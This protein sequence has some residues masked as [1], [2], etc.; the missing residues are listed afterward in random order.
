ME[1]L[2]LHR[3]LEAVMGMVNAAN[4]YFADSAPWALKNDPERR[5]AVLAAALDA[6]RRLALLVQPF[7]PESA[8]KLLD[9][10]GVAAKAR[11]FNGL[12]TPVATGTPLPA[13]QGVFPRWTETPA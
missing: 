10:L 4:L 6:T 13:P 11:D 1:S 9:Q 5:A 3:A 12:D 2:A 7:I 8:G